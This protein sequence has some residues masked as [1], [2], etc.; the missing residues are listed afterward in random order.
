MDTQ[1]L[2]RKYKKPILVM[3]SLVFMYC[4]F[5]TVVLPG[6]L[7]SKIPLWLQQATATQIKIVDVQVQAIPLKIKL[8]GIE[9]QELNGKKIITLDSLLVELGLLR[10]IM[11]LTP[12][13][14]AVQIKKP[15]VQV[16][17]N[18][19]GRFNFQDL[20][21]NKADKDTT[22]S[23]TAT[24]II[25]ENVSLI[26]GMLTVDD[27][28]RAE[29]Y[30]ETIEN[31]NIELEHFS[32]KSDEE[33]QVRLSLDIKS[34]GHIDWQGSIG[35]S[36]INT[37]GHITAN[38]IELNKLITAAMP[39][40][41]PIQIKGYQHI[42]SDYKLSND[43][44]TVSNGNFELKDLQ[45]DVKETG[46]TLLKLPTLAVQ[47]IDVNLN[48]QTLSVT[49][50]SMT[51]ANLQL[52][53]DAQGW[54]YY[55]ALIPKTNNTTQQASINKPTKPWKIAVKA[56]EINK[57]AV[58]YN[59]QRI[60]NAQA[61]SLQ[62]INFKISEY[63]N[64]SGDAP[65]GLDI[66]LNKSGTIKLNGSINTQAKQVKSNL[67]I[68]GIKL[69][70]LQAYI[71]PD[72]PLQITDGTISLDG[73]GV[74]D[75]NKPE[76]MELIFKGNTG[77]KNLLVKDA[78]GTKELLK[79]P[80]LNVRGIDF[81]LG[82][83]TL[84]IA[85]VSSKD[86]NIQAWI[87]QNGEINYQQ[88]LPKQ[89]TE[90]N[91]Q[92]APIN[93]Q[94]QPWGI[95]VNALN[96]SNWG[97]TFQD[98]TLKK[99]LAIQVKPIDIKLEN[100]SNK[101]TQK[102]P[103]V[104]NIGINKSGLVTVKGD[105]V[106]E[107]LSAKLAVNA[108]NID[109]EQFQAYFEK[110]A[111]I[112][113]VDGAV[114]IDGEL[115]IDKQPKTKLDI[116]FQGN[117]HISNLLTR[118]QNQH[119]DLIKWENLSLKNLELNM[120]EQRY[121]AELLEID[122]PYIRVT[123][124]KDKTANFDEVII[125][126]HK[127]KQHSQHQPSQEPPTK[128]QFKLGKI[129]IND[130]SSDFADFS[131]IL[132]FAA[133]IKNLEGGASGISSEQKSNVTLDLKGN[134]YDLS[135]V[136]IKGNISPYLGDYHVN[137]NFSDMP[138]PL[139]SPYMVQFAGYKVEKGK[140]SVGINYKVSHSELSASNNIQIDQ[141]ELGE[142]VENPNA[143]DLPVKLAVALLKDASGK[144]K[145]DV[146]MSGSTDK[147]EFSLG[148]VIA[149]ALMNT[150]SKVI[151]S[152]FSALNSLAYT[153][154]EMSAVGFVSGYAFLDQAQR[155]KLNALSKALKQKQSL[156]IEI[157]GAAF[158]QQDWPVIREDTLYVQLKKR[159]ALEINKEAETKIREEY[160]EL[161]EED[162]KRLLTDMFIEKFPQ[163]VKKSL[164]GVPSLVHP[165]AGE[166]FTVAKQNLFTIIK[167]EQ[168][169]LKELASARAQNIAKYF[170]KNGGIARERVYI[171]DTVIDPKWQNNAVVSRLSLNA[172]N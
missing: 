160:V 125:S 132:P 16:V 60:K 75:L 131:L 29:P 28:F 130:G 144:I 147:P 81:N 56:A 13:L 89:T 36:P 90:T 127:S 27:G 79:L 33:G 94:N 53:L 50:A 73:L 76:Q 3:S 106:L 168:E 88:L 2:F 30:A 165:E 104:I 78:D 143:I 67:A 44:I 163:L 62:P 46:K 151:T 140:L 80:E 41:M 113:V 99:P 14:D 5:I 40:N 137:L 19:N 52:D 64:Q 8:K 39:G 22:K 134:A 43:G 135:P 32:T 158:Q 49:R 114:N 55:R 121:S 119:K 7:K 70:E 47:G 98:Q 148:S 124:N 4:V 1:F 10:T 18:K 117:T 34:G 68:A 126:Q 120:L 172:D 123:I 109:L 20:I 71:A 35:L 91:A 110:F 116:R 108:K 152:P 149:D 138:M 103:A 167:P 105:A 87:N 61:I 15:V 12:V 11:H 155:D 24:P 63:N 146:P 171:L 51:E 141:F 145:L 57:M 25:I 142:R 111:R 69:G 129:Q 150:L 97:V 86:A 38:K 154:K 133:Q 77:I 72:V 84:G 26:A 59:D 48:E 17:R 82:K 65:F 42:E 101:G 83:Q 118:D 166:F 95:T 6:L 107:P 45:I 164:F 102:M 37:A 96:L 161:S 66:S 139:M 9:I 169:R 115:A 170:V 74:I 112:D 136:D 159:R 153:D 54:E 58:N 92:P 128:L 23:T 85:A 162:Y 21:P 93:P 100:Y 157:K 122:S 156:N 31:I